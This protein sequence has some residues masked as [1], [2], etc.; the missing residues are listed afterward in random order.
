MG[1]PRWKEDLSSEPSL[2][3]ALADPVVR[4]MMRRDGVSEAELLRL[5]LAARA[6][7]LPAQEALLHEAVVMPF[8]RRD[9]AGAPSQTAELRPRTRWPFCLAQ[10]AGAPG[11]KP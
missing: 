6:R 10:A 5:M 1:L 11:A 3:E 8:P 9:R 2:H 7:L 4:A